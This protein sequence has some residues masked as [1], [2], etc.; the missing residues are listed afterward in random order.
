MKFDLMESSSITETMER[1]DKKF[2]YDVMVMVRRKKSFLERFFI[3]SFTRHM[4]YVTKK[5]LLIVPEA[6]RASE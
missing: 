4:A 5:P 6:M 1:L 2:P 3:K